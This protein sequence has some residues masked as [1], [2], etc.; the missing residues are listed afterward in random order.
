MTDFQKKYM[1]PFSQTREL[2]IKK[3]DAINLIPLHTD[4]MR[5][6][7]DVNL[8]ITETMRLAIFKNE[9][10]LIITG[11]IKNPITL[12]YEN[13]PL[14]IKEGY[15]IQIKLSVVNFFIT[16]DKKEIDQLLLDGIL[17]EL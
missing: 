11:E 8:Q 10:P 4:R 14:E 7:I 15:F 5:S 3:E 2:Q 13:E 1:Q 17:K 16:P 9:S 12:F 6:N